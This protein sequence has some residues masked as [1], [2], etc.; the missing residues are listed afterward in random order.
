[1]AKRKIVDLLRLDLGGDVVGGM[2][3]VAFVA[4]LIAGALTSVGG[5]EFDTR[6]VRVTGLDCARSASGTG[7]M[8][9][10]DL[11]L[12]SGH[13]VRGLDVLTVELPDGDELMGEIVHI[14]WELDVAVVRVP[15]LNLPDVEYRDP[16]AGE[17]GVIALLDTSESSGDGDPKVVFE[18]FTIER[19][20]RA[21]TENVGRTDVIIRPTLQLASEVESG[22]SG[23]VLFD[24][25]GSAIG[26][27][28][29]TSRNRQNRAYAVQGGQLP[30]VLRDARDAPSGPGGC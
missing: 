9:G 6:A 24:R 15:G 16:G 1:M 5:R 23:G 19:R 10:G 26:L 21:R 14:D 20:I 28:W 3:L 13:V 29:S 18:P 17:A 22:D 2:A 7:A 25:D 12:T 11:V 30:G 4:L 8:V 27:V